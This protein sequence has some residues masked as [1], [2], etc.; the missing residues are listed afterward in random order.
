MTADHRLQGLSVPSE[1]I[2]I[3]WRRSRSTKPLPCN[4]AAPASATVSLRCPIAKLPQVGRAGPGHRRRHPGLPRADRQ[5]TRHYWA[6]V[7]APLEAEAI[8]DAIA[9]NPLVESASNTPLVYSV[10]TNSR[11]TA[12]IMARR[13]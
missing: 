4:P 3:R 2:S 11:T 5:P 10:V 1:R 12:W 13:A 9:A 8:A 6:H 7:S